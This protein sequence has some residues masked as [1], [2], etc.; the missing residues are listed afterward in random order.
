MGPFPLPP[1]PL[2]SPLRS[3][4]E[5]GITCVA[6]TRATIPATTPSALGAAI[7]PPV[8]FRPAAVRRVREEASSSIA[9]RPRGSGLT[10]PLAVPTSGGGRGESAG[11]ATR[12]AFLARGAATASAPCRTCPPARQASAT[13]GTDARAGGGGVAP[14]GV[15]S[16]TSTLVGAGPSGAATGTRTTTPTGA[17]TRTSPTTRPAQAAAVTRTRTAPGATAI[18]GMACPRARA[19]T[20][21]VDNA[22]TAGAT[23]IGTAA[24][25]GAR[26]VGPGRKVTRSGGPT[27]AIGPT[28]GTVSVVSR[29]TGAGGRGSV[30][31]VTRTLT[32]SGATS[33]GGPVELRN[34]D[35]VVAVAGLVAR[36]TPA[37]TVT[38][39]AAA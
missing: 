15:P 36:A 20:L 29:V 33:I 18:D 11:A 5:S 37:G 13:V 38:P 7:P 31:P 6:A 17:A 1:L 19:T 24:R 10:P 22:S 26:R 2:L 12:A 16:S 39:E 3:R 32:F 35:A 23:D 27:T 28:V 4:V 14:A 34:A 30:S 25:P 9:P 21:R 8:A